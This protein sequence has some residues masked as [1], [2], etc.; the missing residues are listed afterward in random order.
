M[1]SI[2]TTEVDDEDLFKINDDNDN[3]NDNNDNTD[4]DLKKRK[5]D[6][7]DVATT[8]T[9]TSTTTTTT[10]STA[11]ATST[12]KDLNEKDIK[13]NFGKGW[14]SLTLSVLSN[15]TS[16]EAQRQQ[17]QQKQQQQQNQLPVV[18]GG[19]FNKKKQ[20]YFDKFN[21]LLMKEMTADKTQ[22]ERRLMKCGINY[23]VANGLAVSNLT[24]HLDGRLFDEIIVRFNSKNILNTSFD[25]DTATTTTTTTSKSTKNGET[26]TSTTST[27]T[28]L[29]KINI[30]DPVIISRH[31]PLYDD[32]VFEGILLEVS[33]SA[34]KVSIKLPPQQQQLQQQKDNTSIFRNTKP[35]RLDYGK[36]IE[37][38]CSQYINV[39]KPNSDSDADVSIPPDFNEW[40][41]NSSQRNA[42]LSSVKRR[43]SL[44]QGPPGTG[45]SATAINLVR[46][47]CHIK[48]KLSA[49]DPG[50]VAASQ[51]ILVTSYTNTGVDN[52]LDGLLKYNV[53]VLRL[54]HT[55]SVR[56]D[57]LNATLD[58]HLSEAIKQYEKSPNYNPA[59][60]ANIERDTKSKLLSQVNVICTTCIASGHPILTNE[61]FSIVIVDEA[62][63]ATEPAILVPLL[64]QSEQLFLF[65]D[66]NQLSP[67]IF[68]K[69]AE[70]GGL[71][72][73]LF[74][75]LAN[76]ITPFLLE[77]QYRMHSKLL[78]FPNKY[79]YDGKLKTGI[80]D[81]D[82]QIPRGFD[83][84]REQCPIAFVNV[85]GKE[86][87]NNY[88]YMNMPEAKEIVRILKAMVKENQ[89][90]TTDSFGIITPY[91]SQA[92]LICNLLRPDFRKLP[93]VATVDS[94]QGREKE[95]ILVSTVRSNLGG[96]VGFLNDW[97]RLN[98]SLTRAKRGMIIVGNKQTLESCPCEKWN[99][100]IQWCTDE[101]L[102]VLPQT[103]PIVNI[104]SSNKKKKTKDNN[105][106]KP[107]KTEKN[108]NNKNKK[109]KS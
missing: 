22:I 2:T 51:K 52:L 18:M 26:A 21:T 64:K 88:S 84:P 76:D 57:L 4:T 7:E 1:N 81:K 43:V 108:K 3:D 14:K 91:S 24:A 16:S 99:Q 109:S 90:L 25:G 94:F 15:N 54:G 40:R 107:T 72:I 35:W 98:V 92:K 34:I 86:D 29:L 78:E 50:G 20:E 104:E 6:V 42:I 48:E 68:T 70:D 105:I 31:N 55:S 66:Q 30:G 77:E 75:R 47:L 96:R 46:L 36:T 5:R 8:T 82:R 95:I 23:L 87:I 60:I 80:D 74:Q 63:Q 65:G 19:V 33:G 38:A 62:S 49:N 12:T 89:D 41:M 39:F 9:N 28:P 102:I 71:S 85:V 101:S 58:H 56:P 106:E 11:S 27:S 100:Y 83:W 61:R 103:Q 53:K 10:S 32:V 69:E 67:T 97:R 93:T 37:Q 45:K 59:N 73:G 44:I 79:I 13:M 17:Q